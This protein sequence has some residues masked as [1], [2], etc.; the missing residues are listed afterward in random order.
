MNKK[1]FVLSGISIVLILAA[2]RFLAHILTSGQ[3]GYF[4]DELYTIACSRHPDF[5]YVDIP[6]LV[7]NVLAVWGH[8]F[9]Y[10]M[11]SVRILPA[12]NGA[13]LVV[14]GGLTAKELGGGRLAQGLTALA[15]LIV[16]VW[17]TDLLGEKY[18]LPKAVSGHLSYFI[19]GYGNNTGETEIA[20][21]ISRINL[22]RFYADVKQKGT[23]KSLYAMSR[24]NNIPLFVCRKPKMKISQ[25]WSLVKHYD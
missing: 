23:V 1:N 8:L 10:S 2:V 25:A 4:I 19:W 16:P 5:G 18:G 24:E 7:P 12:F 13:M 17:L 14:L 21:N 3:Y 11:T 15:V 20:V 6:P 9:G 22:M